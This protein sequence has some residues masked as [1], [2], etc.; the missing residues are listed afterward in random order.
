MVIKLIQK[1]VDLSFHKSVLKMSQF[2]L[3]FEYSVCTGSASYGVAGKFSC[4]SKL[5]P[6]ANM[7]Y[8]CIN[9]MDINKI[10]TKHISHFL[11]S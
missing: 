5:K 2:P 9:V 1:H 8:I 3:A 4:V 10:K 7:I 6:Q 11:F